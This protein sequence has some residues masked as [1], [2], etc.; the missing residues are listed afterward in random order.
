RRSPLWIGGGLL[1]LAA[2]VATLLMAGGSGTSD[3]GSTLEGTRGVPPSAAPA[4]SISSPP[5]AAYT[6]VVA[7]SSSS[8]SVGGGFV[9]IS[10]WVLQSCL[11]DNG[12][13]TSVDKQPD[14]T[15]VANAYR[16]CRDFLP[17]MSVPD[18]VAK[19]YDCLGANGV[20]ADP[21][22]PTAP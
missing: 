20:D 21:R 14:M 17:P 15:K 4:T 3:S 13:V 2:V 1:A 11:R 19:L 7:S 10:D 18:D 16:A 8:P 9:L 12:A 6:T 5:A 22:M